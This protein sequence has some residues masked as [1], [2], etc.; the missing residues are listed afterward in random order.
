MNLKNIINE[1]QRA[2]DRVFH[3]T[4][5]AVFAAIAC[6]AYRQ[7]G[8]T[9]DEL[10]ACIAYE[11]TALYANEIVD[12]KPTKHVRDVAWEYNAPLNEEDAQ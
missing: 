11:W 9:E 12:N 5:K 10:K 4:P 7:L 3:E 6:S 8:I 2:L 1:D